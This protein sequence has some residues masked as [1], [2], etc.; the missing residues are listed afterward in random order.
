V[1]WCWRIRYEKRVTTAHGELTGAKI[2]LASGIL[3]TVLGLAGIGYYD[4][5][6]EA[7]KHDVKLAALGVGG[8]FTLVGGMFTILGAATL[9][10]HD[11]DVPVAVP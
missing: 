3:F 6:G 11:S 5:A 9:R 8:A 4:V 10:A 2:G 1:L 7:P